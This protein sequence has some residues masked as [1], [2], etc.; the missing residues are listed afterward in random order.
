M[1]GLSLADLR[2]RVQA[3]GYGSDVATQI[4]LAINAAQN[5][6]FAIRRWPFQETVDSNAVTADTS[7]VALS[8][9]TPTFDRIDAVRLFS[10]DG[11]EV[12]VRYLDPATFRQ[13]A[14]EFQDE[15]AGPFFW[16]RYAEKILFQPA[17]DQAYTMQLEGVVAP[18]V[19]VADGDTTLIPQEYSEVL[20]WGA[21]SWMA[22][23]QR[24]WAARA[25][26][27]EMFSKHL[28]A[29]LTA[30]VHEQRQNS[31]EVARWDG[32]SEVGGGR[33]MWRG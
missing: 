7:E 22:F 9:I 33:L 20:V 26:A 14:W 25:V 2:S 27:E 5:R 30:Y 3:L 6:V 17:T 12:D 10:S 31:S 19:L 1:A 15:S 11:E 18:T 29:M 8:S 23:R 16:T 24:D 32:W 28:N 4:N 13:R 21:A